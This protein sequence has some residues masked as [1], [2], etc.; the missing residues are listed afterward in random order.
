MRVSTFT[1]LTPSKP[2]GT[3]MAKILIILFEISNISHD[4]KFFVSLP[5]TSTVVRASC[6][7]EAREQSGQS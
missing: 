7:G 5:P 2:F 1:L 4:K 6:S 3:G